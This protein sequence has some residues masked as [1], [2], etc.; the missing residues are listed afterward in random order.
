M[1]QL[2]TFRPLA[3]SVGKSLTFSSVSSTSV[4]QAFDAAVVQYTR[5][6]IYNSALP[7]SG[8]IAFFRTGVGAQ[9]ATANDTPVPPGMIE[10]FGKGGDDNIAII[11]PSG[12][13]TL[14]VTAGEGI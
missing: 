4:N 8:A 6:R 1:S 9:V 7:S 3:G 2:D 14:Y 13:A 10:V 5:I 11:V 12:T